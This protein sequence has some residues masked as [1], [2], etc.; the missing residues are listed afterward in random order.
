MYINIGS[1][2]LLRDVE[3]VA[4]ITLKLENNYDYNHSYL[5]KQKENNKI[6]DISAGNAKSI[7]I[8]RDESVYISPI[9][10]QTILMRS[11]NFGLPKGMNK[12][13]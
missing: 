9:T 6:I 12:I 1:E 8:L 11:K 7:V 13:G 5:L 2:I 4:V 10:S 3:I